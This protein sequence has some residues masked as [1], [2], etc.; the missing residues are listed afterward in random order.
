M[1]PAA[2]L[3]YLRRWRFANQ[4]FADD[5][6]LIGLEME[7]SQ[8]RI[9]ISQRP[10]RGEAPSGEELHAAMTEFYGLHLLETNGSVGAHESKA[11]TG[12]RFAIFG[13]RTAE[14]AVV[15]FDVI[16]QAFNRADAAV[17]RDLRERV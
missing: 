3:Q 11:Y 8:T 12:S 6:E 16:P 4:L 7:G 15:P 9:V 17:L 14:E 2:L 1:L 10:L 5:V 13:V